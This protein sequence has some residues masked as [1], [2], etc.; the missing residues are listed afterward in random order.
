MK[1]HR[2]KTNKRGRPAKVPDLASQLKK[3][4]VFRM[5]DAKRIGISQSSL[6]RMA[7]SGRIERLAPGLYKHP[8]AS[9]SGEE[10]DFAVACTRFKPDAVVGGM[11]AL[12]HYGL[13]EQV[14]QRIWVMLPYERRVH[15]PLYRCIRTKTP[16]DK[17][18]D[19]HKHYRITSLE[20]TI[21]EAFR[22]AS[23]IGLR[24]AFRAARTAI[25]ENRTTLQKIYR[26]AKV[27]GLER[28][29]QRHWEA[30]TPEGRT[31]H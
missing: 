30:L 24:T 8:K 18:V 25:Q 10:L 23:K 6:S 9:I 28:F 27:L 3:L 31:A 15:D 5:E 11:T 7:S 20:R 12:F 17:G 19:V 22:Y 13:I 2:T 29:I 21:V 16:F 1:G 14:P 4:G 26:E